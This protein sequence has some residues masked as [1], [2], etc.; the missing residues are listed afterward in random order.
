MFGALFYYFRSV[1]VRNRNWIAVKG[2]FF[3]SSLVNKQAW[4][5]DDRLAQAAFFQY[6]KYG[7][8]SWLWR[9]IIM[10]QNKRLYAQGKS[11]KQKTLAGR[12]TV[13]SRSID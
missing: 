2:I 12:Q 8:R 13:T 5:L 1:L 3:S 6:T 4:R 7:K 10:W 11:K 9:I